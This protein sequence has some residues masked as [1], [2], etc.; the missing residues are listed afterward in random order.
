M[1]KKPRYL[2]D[3]DYVPH[4]W[5]QGTGITVSRT[6]RTPDDRIEI[7]MVLANFGC[8][9]DIALRAA[10]EI[11]SEGSYST[12]VRTSTALCRNLHD[13]LEAAGLAI[14]FEAEIPEGNHDHVRTPRNRRREIRSIRYPGDVRALIEEAAAQEGPRPFR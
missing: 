12:R 3:G 14:D 1:S 11:L 10:D 2:P 4:G 13:D 7:A 6:D 8:R 9:P 5:P